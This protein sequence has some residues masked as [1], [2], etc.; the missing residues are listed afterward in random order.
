MVNAEKHKQLL[1]EHDTRAVKIA[2]NSINKKNKCNKGFKML[3][4]NCN[5]IKNNIDCYSKD[6]NDFDYIMQ[7]IVNGTIKVKGDLN[8]RC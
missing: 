7:G 4:S 3:N 1:K 2:K 5:L 8:G 6:D